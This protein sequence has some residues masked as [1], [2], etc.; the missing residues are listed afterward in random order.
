MKTLLLVCVL[1]SGL[2]FFSNNETY[3]QAHE[4]GNVILTPSIGIGNWGYYNWGYWGG[5]SYSFP[6]AFNA[7][8]AVH[9]YAGVGPFAGLLINSNY[10]GVQF[11]ERGTFNWW[12]LLD[13]KVAKDLKGDVL[14]IYYSLGLGYE[15][16]TNSEWGPGLS[17]GH[18]NRFRWGSSMGVRWYFSERIGLMGEVGAPIAAPVQIGISFKLN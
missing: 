18:W 3:A 10:L 9:D 11:G 8:F 14:D 13:D 7:D 12:Q 16:F 15:I 4:K 2:F 1:F 5:R 17:R 6:V